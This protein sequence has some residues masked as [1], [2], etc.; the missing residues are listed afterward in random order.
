MVSGGCVMISLT[1]TSSSSP[2][3]GSSSKFFFLDVFQKS[4]ILHHLSKGFAQH[5][6]PIR[7]RPR[8]SEYRPAQSAVGEDHAC[9]APT[10]LGYLITVHD[11]IQRRYIGQARIAFPPGLIEVADE[12]FLFPGNIT[13]DYR[14]LFGFDAASLASSSFALDNSSASATHSSVRVLNRL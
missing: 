12:A 6:Y 14:V 8:G 13:R 7:R 1:M 2:L 4:R 11:L 9:Q 10:T 5:L 3:I